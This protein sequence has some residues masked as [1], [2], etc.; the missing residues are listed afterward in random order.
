M[1]PETIF[2]ILKGHNGGNGSL[3]SILEDIQNQFSYLPR[4]A[5]EIVSRET[6]KSLVDIYGVATF[7]K[8][9]KLTPRGEHLI[10]CCLGTACHVRRAPTIAQELQ[11]QL[12][13]KSGETTKDK[14][15]TLETVNCLGACA[16][17][18]V[19]VVDGKYFP[20]VNI[21]QVREIIEN[22]RHG[23]GKID[24][25]YDQRIIPV[26]VSCSRCNHS[27]MDSTYPIDN[28]PSIKMSV[29]FGRQHGWVRMSSL[30][31]SN[32]VELEHEIPHGNVAELFCPHCHTELTGSAN[33]PECGSK[34]ASMIIRRGGAIQVCAKRGCKGH[35]LDVA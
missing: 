3:I 8:L 1:N 27:L 23:N 9:F 14:K 17:G 12:G 19:V 10:S 32:S 18:P 5:L 13:I 26:E 29:S 25:A 20:N 33:C 24:L 31:G 15:F 4:E 6:G 21:A 2:K 16:L 7:Y 28:L 30:Y 11:R 22:V 35:L 34:M